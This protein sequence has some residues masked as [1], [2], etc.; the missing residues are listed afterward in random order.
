M[1]DKF[2]K[3]NLS[4]PTVF[5]RLAMMASGFG[6]I[7]IFVGQTVFMFIVSETGPSQTVTLSSVDTGAGLDAKRIE[8]LLKELEARP[9]RAESALATTTL[10]VDPSL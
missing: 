2:K 4:D 10:F 7:L 9:L 6:L 8:T 3:I 1:F 5:W